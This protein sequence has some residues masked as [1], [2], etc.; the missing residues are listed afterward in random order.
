MAKAWEY[1]IGHQ[2]LTLRIIAPSMAG[3]FHLRCGAC[4]RVEFDTYR[5][6]VS[7]QVERHD[8]S[9]LVQDGNHLRVRCGIIEGFYNIAPCFG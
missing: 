2:W 9:F 1:H 7:T 4:E 6:P 5:S 3:N 8:D